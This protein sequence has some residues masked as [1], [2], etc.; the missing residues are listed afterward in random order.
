MHRLSD[1]LMQCDLEQK[2]FAPQIRPDQGSNSWSPDHDTIYNIME[3]PASTTQL[4]CLWLPLHDKCIQCIHN[5]PYPRENGVFLLGETS[6][7]MVL[8]PLLRPVNHLSVTL[9]LGEWTGCVVTVCLSV[10]QGQGW[11]R[12]V[13]L[14]KPGKRCKDIRCHVWPF[15]FSKPAN[16]QLRHQATCKVG[17]QPVSLLKLTIKLFTCPDPGN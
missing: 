4:P 8:F 17:W 1:R 5:W 3:M 11:V 15:F 2:Y 9:S 13:L 10:N 12:Y 16:Y 6:R 14:M 7:Y